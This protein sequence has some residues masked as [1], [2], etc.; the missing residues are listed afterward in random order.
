M[1]SLDPGGIPHLPFERVPLHLVK[2]EI[3][4]EACSRS[5]V[6]RSGQRDGAL[7]RAGNYGFE[8]PDS[9]DGPSSRNHPSS[10]SGTPPGLALGAG[11]H[12]SED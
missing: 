10:P 7:S 5:C 2:R 12:W 1:A 11:Q 8:T 3:S 9:L 6:C 4:L